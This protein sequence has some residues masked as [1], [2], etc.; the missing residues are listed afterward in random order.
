[1]RTALLILALA[2]SALAQQGRTPTAAN[3]WRV[4]PDGSISPRSGRNVT[5]VATLPSTGIV[6]VSDTTLTLDAT[7]NGK[8]IKSTAGTDAT[9]MLNAGV[10]TAGYALLI[11]QRG[12]G[13]VTVTAGAGVTIRQRQSYTKT[14]GQYAV[15]SLV[16]DVADDCILSGDLQ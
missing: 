14:A 16:C 11:S 5:I 10:G 8:I 12:A 9:Y 6:T 3:P 1:M 4:N 13:T 7:H 15:A 2:A